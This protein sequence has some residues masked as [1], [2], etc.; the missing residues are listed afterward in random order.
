MKTRTIAI[1][2]AGF[3]G[4]TLAVRLLRNPTATQQKI[5]LI[6][7]PGSIARGIA[8]G[9]HSP[10]H[11]LNVPADR[12]NALSDDEDSF[13]EFAKNHDSDITPG[14]FVQRQ[15]YGDYLESLLDD[16]SQNAAQGRELQNV[17][18]EVVEV[19]PNTADD[20]AHLIMNNG[21]HFEVDKVVLSI[22]SCARQQ[23]YSAAEHQLF[24]ANPRYIHD[25]WKADALSNVGSDTPVF[26]IGSGLTMLDV[27][28]DLRDRGHHGVIHAVSRRG[29][30]PQPHRVLNERPS[31]DEHLS[32]RMLDNCT[33]RHYLRAVR[34]AIKHQ[35]RTGGDWR[36]VIG[37]LRSTTAQ[38]WHA[39]PIIERQRFLRHVRP[40]WDTHRHRCAPQSGA[41]LQTEITSGKLKLFAGRVTGFA[42]NEEY[43]SVSFQRRGTYTEESIEVGA[44]INCTTPA[45]DLRQL[46]DPL[47]ESLRISGLLIPDV[48]G[49]SIAIA[50]SGALVG[51]D[52]TESH[53]LYYVGPFL[54]ARDWEATA[55]P[56]LRDYV[57]RLAETLSE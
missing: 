9:T 37:G 1:I 30:A 53:W 44:V 57:K 51:R 46:N 18:G 17:I 52:G 56:E 19:I 41:R 34:D 21:D 22:G 38:L 55:V 4:S 49:T 13:L 10:A 40:Y 7:R 23:P 36:D 42:P 45:F 39:L 12:M 31:Y 35:A 29:L 25:P 3:C 28:L 43:V 20:G 8:Y 26:L 50:P 24:Y 27:V 54:Q 2:G 16:A 6:S 48:L 14:S 15:L 5:L 33:T 11:V 47:L 32:R